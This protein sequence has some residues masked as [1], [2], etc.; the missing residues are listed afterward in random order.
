MM[1]EKNQS[2]KRVPVGRESRA[3]AEK[4]K[5]SIKIELADI[6]RGIHRE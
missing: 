3:K 2:L 6:F 4:Q 1:R 5:P